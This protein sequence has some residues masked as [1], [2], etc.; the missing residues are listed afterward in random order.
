MNSMR[1]LYVEDDE[2]IAEEIAYFLQSR[3]KELYIAHDGEEGYELYKK[4]HPDLILTDIQMPKMNGL[5]MSEKIRAEDRDTPIIIISAYNDTNF[6]TRSISLG[7][8]NYLTK[9]INLSDMAHKIEKAYELQALRKELQHRNK[10]LEA[11]NKNLDA[12]VAKKTEDLEFLYY[13]DSLTSLYNSVALEKAIKEGEFSYLVLLDIANFSYINKQYGKHFGNNV[14]AT[15]AELLKTHCNSRIKLYKIESDRFV[16]LLHEIKQQEAEE[17]CEQI[18]SFFDTKKFEIDNIPIGIA[19]NIGIASAKAGKDVLIQAEYALDIAKQLGARYYA[20]YN[21]EDEVIQQNKQMIEWL[22][23]T[24]EMIEGD[25][26]VPY[27]QPI[28]ESK[29]NKIIK[30]EVLARGIYKGKVIIPFY[31]IEP[32]TRL[33]LI[34]AITRIM[35]QKSFQH[36]STNSFEFSLNISERD[37]HEAY[38]YDY[39]KERAKAFGIDPSRVTLEILESVT[40]GLHHEEITE[41]INK[42]KSLGFKVAIDDFGT[43]NANF[44]RLMHINFDYIK[45]D[46]TFMKNIDK[47]QRQQLIVKSIVE[48]A[49]VLGI[50]TI[51]EF[52]ENET[53]CHIARD[54]GVDMLQGYYLGKPSASL[55]D[56]SVCR[57]E[58][59]DDE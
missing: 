39:L 50:E 16:F 2:D 4:Y 28:L 33:G 53:V 58:E 9:P 20:F 10:E 6:L 42:I 8:S 17:F 15:V 55:V 52:I 18:Q 43:E 56:N 31:F 46:G 5:D 34:S 3:V 1:V 59:G 19:F 23:I 24:K 11:I 44:S 14:L 27:F 7:I 45:L 26:I 49:K 40:T 32:A 48:L 35:I 29:S 47:S 54:C 38:L 41:Q 37:L 25:M 22:N 51:A 36:F 12:I 30:F 13:H 57:D 21:E